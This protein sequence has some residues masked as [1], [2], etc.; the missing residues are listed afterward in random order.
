M[1]QP[2]PPQHFICPMTLEVMKHPY[3][4]RQTKFNFERDSILEWM[5]FGNA[6][7]PLTRRRLHP[8]DFEENDELRQEIKE[9]KT[10]EQRSEDTNVDCCKDCEDFLT[11]A[12]RK[13]RPH[14]EMTSARESHILNL[15]NRVLL[16][17]DERIR[18]SG[19]A[20]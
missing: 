19:V 10:R 16:K 7:C 18:A 6:T 15:R 20:V 17:R 11:V 12:P 8:D 3:R 5:Y 13:T 2:N 1:S 14:K 9:W 4:H